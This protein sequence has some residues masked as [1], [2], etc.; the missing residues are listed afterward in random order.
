MV[1]YWVIAPFRNN[2]NDAYEMDWHPLG[3][4][5]VWNYDKE[6]GVI[7]IGWDFGDLTGFS[8]E[9][10]KRKYLA[11][12]ADES[13]GYLSIQRFWCDISP[14][15]RVI[16]RRGTKKIVGVGTVTGAPIYDPDRGNFRTGGLPIWGYPN[17][18]PVRWHLLDEFNLR[19]S[20]LPR[21]TVA[22]LKPSH[23]HW[24]ALRNVLQEVWQDMP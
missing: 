3:Y 4:D 7:A 20:S 8:K 17:F 24:P 15:D 9:T 23:K 10:I 19:V 14:D 18:L 16:A 21:D 2:G 22:E 13:R 1:R 5:T 11:E 12:Y 6:N